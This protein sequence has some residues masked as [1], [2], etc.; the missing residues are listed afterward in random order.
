MWRKMSH[1]FPFMFGYDKKFIIKV[2]DGHKFVSVRYFFLRIFGNFLF[3][4]NF[5]L[6]EKLRE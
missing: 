1:M 3:L 4:Y 2:Q 6:I 5:K